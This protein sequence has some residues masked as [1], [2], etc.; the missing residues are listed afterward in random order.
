MNILLGFEVGTGEAVYIDPDHLLETGLTQQ[1]GKT[2]ALNALIS[3]SKR[4]AIAFRTKRGEIDWVVAKHLQPFYTQ[5]KQR[6]GFIDWEYVESILEAHLGERVKFER[7]WIM[8]VCESAESL[9]EVY[10]NSLRLEKESKHFF[11]KGQFYLLSNYFEKI[12][13]QLESREWATTLPLVEGVN[14]MDLEDMSFEMQCLVI[15]RVMDYVLTSMKNVIIVLPEARVFI[16]LSAKTPVTKTAVKMASEGAVL[17]VDLWVDSQTYSSINSEV[18]KQCGTQLH[19]VQMDN[20]EAKT[21]TDLLDKKWKPRQLK[22]L[23]LGHFFVKT[24]D[25]RYKHVYVLPA[26]ISE[27]DGIAVATGKLRV[28]EIKS[29]LMDLAPSEAVQSKR[30]DALAIITA[31]GPKAEIKGLVGKFRTELDEANR[32]LLDKEE[33]LHRLQVDYA[34]EKQELEIRVEDLGR[35]I[36]EFGVRTQGLE[37]EVNELAV[38]AEGAVAQNTQLK[39]QIKEKDWAIDNLKKDLESERGSY[40]ELRGAHERFVAFDNALKILIDPYIERF[41]QDSTLPEILLN[42]E[43]KDSVRGIVKEELQKMTPRVRRASVEGDTGIAWV[44]I[45]LPKLGSAEAKILRFMAGKF[46]LKMTKSQVAIGVG[47]TAKG[48]H[49]SGSFNN[50]VKN[51]LIIMDGDNYSLAEGPS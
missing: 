8:Q 5:P 27:E 39:T 7:R 29:M 50:L 13:P 19:G 48:G 37:D 2:T 28:E 1:S 31:S 42:I 34:G 25:K 45:W 36:E 3:R 15:E 35:T 21:I 47:L 23:K 30:A 24:K 22:S 17:E 41:L 32:K 18:R 38:K 16:P 40:E 46:P 14:L 26:G 49:F 4:R 51:K 12:L 10:A 43:N 33:E 11:D 44:D 20:N 9:K 6:G